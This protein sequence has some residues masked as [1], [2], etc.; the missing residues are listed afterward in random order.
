M[1]GNMLTQ[2]FMCNGIFRRS[3]SAIITVCDVVCHI[4]EHVKIIPKS[5]K[6]LSNWNNNII[7]KSGE[8]GKF[9]FWDHSHNT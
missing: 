6:I 4:P 9:Q 2:F 7:P 8:D 3:L 1:V 5:S